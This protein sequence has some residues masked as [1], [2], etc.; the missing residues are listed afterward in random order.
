[1]GEADKRLRPW[2]P[3]SSEYRMPAGR[4]RARRR[5]TRACSDAARTRRGLDFQPHR[6]HE[7]ERVAVL[8]H[9]GLHAVVE[10]HDAVLEMVGEVDVGGARRQ[11]VGGMASVFQSPARINASASLCPSCVAAALCSSCLPQYG[12]EAINVPE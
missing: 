12:A 4:G 7:R 8:H 11:R 9:P 10:A 3:T 2:P 5:R 1:M 6:A